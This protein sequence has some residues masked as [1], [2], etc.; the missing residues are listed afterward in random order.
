MTQT[1]TTSLTHLLL[2]AG[3]IA[4]L[5]G[6]LSAPTA[7]ARPPAK[8]ARAKRFRI[9]KPGNGQFAVTW[10]GHAAFEIVTAAGTRVLIDPFLSANPMTPAPLKDPSGHK[11]DLI[12]VTHSH[13]DHIGDTV[14]IAQRSGA[15]VVGAYDHIAS[16]VLPDAQKRGGNVGGTIKIKDVT[17]HIVPAMHGSSP[18]GRP[19]GFVLTFAGGGSL[20]HSGDTW[21]FGDMALI[22]ELYAPSVLLL[23][24][25]GGPFTQ[26]PKTAALA[27]RRYFTHAKSIVPMHFGTFPPLAKEAEVRAAFAKD[28][29]LVL[30]KPGQTR[31]F[32][33]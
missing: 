5:C 22:D 18:G 3:L 33:K 24:A 8:Q 19:V 12:L 9:K 30:M 7:H 29:R 28:K 20:Y 26:D 31:V 27:A 14:A 2:R 32:G 11:P 10:L 23:N 17:V 4:G 21:I 6:A 25:G 16:L 13:G 15:Q 1:H